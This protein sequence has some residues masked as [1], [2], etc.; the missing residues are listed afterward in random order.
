MRH[1]R[2]NHDAWNP[3]GDAYW[4]SSKGFSLI[5]VLVVIFIIGVISLIYAAGAPLIKAANGVANEDV[6]L[7]AASQELEKLRAGGYATLPA[8][9]TFSNTQLTTL[10]SGIGNE[11]IADFNPT[12]KQVTVMVSWQEISGNI[13]SVSL[14][15]LI[16]QTGGI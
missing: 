2:N 1:T 8:S 4:R 3:R 10:P 7:H 5:E 6:A 16:T 12:I 15:T 13:R 11:T 9:G 14:S